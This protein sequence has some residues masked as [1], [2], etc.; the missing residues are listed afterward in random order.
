MTLAV[1]PA[2]CRK[3]KLLLSK[4]VYFCRT[5][6]LTAYIESGILELYALGQL[7]PEEREEAERMISVFP[8]IKAEYEAI[9]L[10]LERYAASSAIQPP[11]AVKEKLKATIS[12]LE[13]EKEMNLQN[14][15]LITK[16]S[17]HTRWMDLVQDMLPEELGDDGMYTSILHQSEKVVQLLV[18]TSTDIGDE[19]HDESHE[20]F[21]ILKGRCKCTV[22]NE[23]RFM[24]E[25]DYMPIPLY[26]HHDV[27]IISDRVV[28]ILQHVAV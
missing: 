9:Q 5:M 2:R 26:E 28:A 20:S 14:L 18:V 3:L 23:V 12:N 16:F 11:A 19:V 17:D 21:L 24:E 22:G 10:S 13:K 4:N 1:H 7:D 15:P 6:N 27:E 8:E 25:G